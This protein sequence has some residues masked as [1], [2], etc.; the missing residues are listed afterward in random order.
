MEKS[1]KTIGQY[2]IERLYDMGIRHIFG[3]PGDYVL[4]FYKMIEKS[5]IKLVGTTREDCAGFAADAYARVRGLGCVCVTYCVG[6]L[7][8][9]NP[10]AGAYAEKSP[11]VVISGAPGLRERQKNALLHH[12]VREFTTQKEIFEKITVASTVL[13]SPLTALREIDRVLLA[14]VEYK[15]PVYIEL[16]RD[17]VDVHCLPLHEHPKPRESSSKVLFEAVEE[18]VG[19]INHSKRP[20]IFAGAEIHRYNLQ[21]QLVELVNK[22]QIPVC[23]SLLGKS[24]IRETHPLYF[25]IY[26]G[27]MGR[28]EV[29][30]YV[31]DS[32]CVILLGTYMTDIDLG[33][34]AS[35]IMDQSRCINATAEK[36]LVKYHHY[37]DVNFTD[38]MNALVHGAIHRRPRPKLPVQQTDNKPFWPSNKKITVQRLFEGLNHYI[39][40]NMVVVSDIGDCLFG[41]ADLVIKKRTEFLS[42]AYY[43]SMGFG[44]PAAVG[45][46]LASPK[47]RLI[48]VVG[49]GAFHMTGMELSTCVRL[50]LDPVI[51]VMNNHGYGTERHILEGK[52]NDITE[53]NFSKIPVIFSAGTG[54]LVK[55]E[56][57]FVQS[58]ESA[59]RHRGA[60]S[61]I[62][63]QLDKMDHSPAMKRLAQRL[64]RVVHHRGN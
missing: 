58:L 3:I 44:I 53:W 45:A 1:K 25:G 50:G 23:A 63:V 12:K 28:E 8:L 17:M 24:V 14:A 20:V 62:D 36:I 43:T 13:D 18:A 21:D 37:E 49:D 10:I 2:L 60:F 35:R 47:S 29:S 9:T 64:S 15:R 33:I 4:K 7:N 51:I 26:E 46:Q 22:T 57:E 11:V 30:R 56:K 5:K 52:F 16:P 34:E 59:L 19:M 61:I 48:V 6:G 41:A 39:S 31:D 38:F 40:D 27:S 42:P 54:Y 55:T 32:D